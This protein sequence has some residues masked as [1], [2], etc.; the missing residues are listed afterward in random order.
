MNLE[1]EELSSISRRTDQL[2]LDVSSHLI[3]WILGFEKTAHPRRVSIKLKAGDDCLQ[4][5]IA[6]NLLR[7]ALQTIL[8]IHIDVLHDVQV[9][10]L[11]LFRGDQRIG[12]VGGRQRPAP[13][14]Y[15]YPAHKQ[16]KQYPPAP[17]HYDGEILF[18]SPRNPFL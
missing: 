1:S 8:E 4:A 2:N 18:P 11:L 13:S 9:R 16:W 6:Q 15:R 7:R 12:R 17:P 5:G 14:P 10:H 3:H